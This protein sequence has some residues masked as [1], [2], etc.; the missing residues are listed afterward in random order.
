M[1]N[2]CIFC[3]Q[4]PKFSMWSIWSIHWC[5]MYIR[6]LTSIELIDIDYVG[7]PTNVGGKMWQKY[8]IHPSFT[9]TKLK[10]LLIIAWRFLNSSPTSQVNNIKILLF[11]KTYYSGVKTTN[12]SILRAPRSCLATSHTIQGKKLRSIMKQCMT[13]LY[14]NV[15]S[16]ICK[17]TYAHPQ[18]LRT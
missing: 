11:I 5:K 4:P 8:T 7:T 2:L 13:R 14:R 15:H 12:T 10:V 16:L 9:H 1:G 6:Y 17:L 3:Y 18:Y